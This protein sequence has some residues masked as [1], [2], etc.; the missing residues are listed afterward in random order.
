MS[1]RFSLGAVAREAVDRVLPRLVDERIAS[2]ITAQD[3]SLW[4]RDTEPGAL[5]RLGWTEAVARSRPLVPRIVALRDRARRS[6][7]ERVLLVAP[8]AT[9]LGA[10]TVVRTQGLELDVLTEPS[11]LG[12]VLPAGGATTA[13]V[14]AQPADATLPAGLVGAARRL[15]AE[16]GADPAQRLVVVAPSGSALERE[17][18][19]AGAAVLAAEP[20]VGDAFSV[21][22]PAGLVAAGL[23]GADLGELLDEAESELLDL[24]IDAPANNGL[25][26]AAALAGTDPRRTRIAIV[27]AGTHLVGFAEWAAH[28]LVAATSALGHAGLGAFVLPPEHDL[29]PGDDL[30]VVRLVADAGDGRGQR[31]TD[32]ELA[33]S[34]TLGELLLVWQTAT[35]AAGWLLGTDPFATDRAVA[36]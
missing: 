30:L 1:V 24:A 35:A 10:A 16:A 27:A 6:G 25:V 11:R 15:L 36:P 23:A 18:Q 31:P 14:L 9:A 20:D 32:D 21:L 13:V 3:D 2:A 33:V 34:G 19:E 7:A 12:E 8:P 28:L 4:G 5:P 26:L 29:P 22:T 17:A